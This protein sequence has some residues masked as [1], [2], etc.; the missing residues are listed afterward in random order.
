MTERPWWIAAGTVM[1]CHRAAESCG[2][3]PARPV[4]RHWPWGCSPPSAPCW[5]LLGAL[6]ALQIHRVTFEEQEA[7]DVAEDY[8]ITTGPSPLPRTACALPLLTSEPL[9]SSSPAPAVS[10]WSP[11][12]SRAAMRLTPPSGHGVRAGQ[13][14]AVPAP[15]PA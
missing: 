14:V 1:G 5:W 3:A 7:E 4:C 6:L 12:S 8:F 13:L 2:T 10:C 15:R 11:P 9:A